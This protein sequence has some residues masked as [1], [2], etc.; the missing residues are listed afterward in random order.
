[1]PEGLEAEIYREAA[2]AFVGSTL[3]AVKVDSACGDPVALPTLLGSTVL[4]ARRHGKQVLLDT[5]HGVLGLQFMTTERV[6]SR[7]G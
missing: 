6:S 2:A 1:M 5:T 4:A 3:T 7:S